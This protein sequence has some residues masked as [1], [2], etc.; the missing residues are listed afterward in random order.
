MGVLCKD[1]MYFNPHYVKY[2]NGKFVTTGCGH[3][4]ESG[5]K[6]RDAYHKACKKWEESEE[7]ASKRG[8]MTI[9]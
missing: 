1:C 7:V 2:D 5:V 4:T 6:K 9:G 8:K 3:C